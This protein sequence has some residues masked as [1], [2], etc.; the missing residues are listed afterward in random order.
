MKFGWSTQNSQGTC[1]MVMAASP[2]DGKS[3]PPSLDEQYRCEQMC[4]ITS[5]AASHWWCT[6]LG[7]ARLEGPLSQLFPW[8]TKPR[9]IC[10][11]L[12]EDLP[13]GRGCLS[14]RWQVPTTIPWGAVQVQVKVPNHVRS[15][16]LRNEG[17]LICSK[18][19]GDLPHGNGCLPW[20]WQVPATIP[21]WAVQVWVNVPNHIRS[22]WPWM[23]HHLQQ[24]KAGRPLNSA[25]PKKLNL[26]QSAQ[27]SRGH[28]PSWSQLPLKTA[29][30]YLKPPWSS[31]AQSKCTKSCQEPPAEK[32]SLANLLKIHRGPAPDQEPP[33][34]E[35]VSPWHYSPRSRP[36]MSKC[37]KSQPEPLAIDEAPSS[38][39][40][41]WKAP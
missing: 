9:L 5:G 7:R 28:A 34:L 33:S 6:I 13:H 2:E 35:M 40:L 8:K 26:G 32:W 15:H 37:A 4:Q 3:L 31:T 30:P 19:I 12:T 20:R 38:A 1:P 39:G 21:Q 24:G 16:W 25:S 18:L 27:N 11:K 22:H 29:G 14:W 10:P 17:W 41:G 36:G 23:M